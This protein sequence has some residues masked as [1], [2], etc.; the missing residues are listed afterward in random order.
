MFVEMNHTEYRYVYHQVKNPSKAHT[1]SWTDIE[2]ETFVKIN[3]QFSQEIALRR[4][5]KRVYYAE[6]YAEEEEEGK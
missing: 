2:P 3:R 6:T 5:E 1:S 4:T